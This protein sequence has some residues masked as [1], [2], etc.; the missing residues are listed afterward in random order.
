M[1]IRSDME[2]VLPE[3]FEVLGEEAT[4]TPAGGDP[5]S[6]YILIDFDV[7]LQPDGFSTTA[8]QRSTVIEAVL[9][10]IG[11]EPNRGDIFTYKSTAYTVEKI[12][13]ND[14]LT[15]KVAVTP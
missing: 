4:F 12:T 2:A 10:V 13:S 9:S 5:V 15:V 1:G 8:W 3:M 7:D 11:A 14:G 6:C